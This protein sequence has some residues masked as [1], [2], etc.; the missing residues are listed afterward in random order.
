MV[1]DGTFCGSSAG[2]VREQVWHSGGEFSCAFLY[3]VHRESTE[4]SLDGDKTMVG[5]VFCN[6]FELFTIR[7]Q[8]AQ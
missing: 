6:G 3:P 4:I 8:A 5:W 7:K 2:Y 1:G